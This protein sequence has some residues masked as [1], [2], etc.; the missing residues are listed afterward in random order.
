[1]MMMAAAS[2]GGKALGH[3]SH[4]GG[5]VQKLTRRDI[6]D[7][8]IIQNIIQY[9]SPIASKDFS[10]LRLGPLKGHHQMHQRKNT[11]DSGTQN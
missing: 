7:Q 1:M 4:G 3:V 2:T 6:T 8:R 11:M 5:T 9:N 10:N